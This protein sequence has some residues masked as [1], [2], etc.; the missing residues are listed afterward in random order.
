MECTSSYLFS[1]LADLLTC[2][3]KDI[4]EILPSV[5]KELRLAVRLTSQA[6]SHHA[7]GVMVNLPCAT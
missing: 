2:F 4:N 6:Y 5:S 7:Y 3:A 1:F